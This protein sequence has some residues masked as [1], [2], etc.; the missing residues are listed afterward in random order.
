MWITTARE[1][2]LLSRVNENADPPPSDIE[3]LQ[4]LLVATRAERDA[5]LVERDG[6]IAERD[7]AL[8]QNERLQHLLHQLQRAQFGRRS[9]KL[10]ADQLNLA[11]EDIEQAIAGNE[12]DNDRKDP[13]AAR[14]RAAKRR[15]NRGALPGHLPRLHV[16]VE[17]GDTNCPCCRVPMHVIGEETSQRLDIIPAQYRVIVTHRPEVCLPG[18]RG[19]DGAGAGA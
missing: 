1:F 2:D 18:L 11:F 9:E 17:P 12:A 3:A 15:V 16:T 14:A 19:G 13:V 7:Q 8:S 6:A 10:D 5:A 4:A